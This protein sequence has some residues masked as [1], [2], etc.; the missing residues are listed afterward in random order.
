MSILP[1][2][3]YSGHDKG[4]YESFRYEILDPDSTT[5]T[6]KVYIPKGEA[7]NAVPGC[8]LAMS[9]NVKIEVHIKKSLKSILG[10]EES[11]FQSFTA[12]GGEGWVI[13]T[14]G[15]MGSIRAVRLEANEICLGDDAYLASIGQVESNSESQGLTQALMT[16]G[17]LFVRKI[18]GSGVIFVCGVGSLISFELKKG[19]RMVASNGHLVT[20]P[21]TIKYDIEKASNSWFE[22]GISGEGVVVKLNGPAEILMQTRSPESLANDIT[23]S[24]SS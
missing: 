18:K 24:K 7:L 23:K 13:I 5:A 20:W 16:G 21:A 22:S 6:L 14:P 12:S 8:L 11:R 17:D 1:K 4:E 9:D 3:G 10:P 19:E 15:F 2:S